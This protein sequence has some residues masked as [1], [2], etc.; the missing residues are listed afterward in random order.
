MLLPRSAQ[1]L[2]SAASAPSWDKRP[3]HPGPPVIFTEEHQRGASHL[4]VYRDRLA[5]RH[6]LVDVKL[7]DRHIVQHH[8]AIIDRQ[9]DRLAV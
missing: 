7:R 5:G 1:E 9:G 6:I 2:K 4:H 3:E 8:S